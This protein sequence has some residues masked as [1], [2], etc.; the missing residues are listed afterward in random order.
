MRYANPGGAVQ[1]YPDKT[2]IYFHYSWKNK[3][4]GSDPEVMDI[5]D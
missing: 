3:K 2:H 4:R 5:F 1:I